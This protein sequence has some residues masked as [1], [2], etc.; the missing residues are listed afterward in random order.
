MCVRVC[1]CVCM[2]V[3]VCLCVCV[4]VC[5]CERRVYG[6]T[7]TFLLEF[8][9]GQVVGDLGFGL[10]RRRVLRPGRDRDLPRRQQRDLPHEDRGAARP[11]HERD[12]H[13]GTACGCASSLRVVSGGGAMQQRCTARSETWNDRKETSVNCHC[14]AALSVCFPSNGGICSSSTRTLEYQQRHFPK[15]SNQLHNP[16]EL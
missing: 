2:C 10:R 16:L 1:M 8:L 12:R 14:P 9:L 6:C 13:A 7:R 5:A 4:C 11:E 3:R 15:H